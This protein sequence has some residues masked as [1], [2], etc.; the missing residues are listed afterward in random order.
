MK[1]IVRSALVVGVFL[2][3]FGIAQVPSVGATTVVGDRLNGVYKVGETVRWKI[4]QG[5]AVTARYRVLSGGLTEVAKGELSFDNKSAA[6][7]YTFDKPGTVLLDI[8]AK[9]SEN[10]EAKVLGGAVAEPEKIS[11][12]AQTPEDFD[13]FWTEQ[14]AKLEKIPTNPVLEVVDL[15]QPDIE[16]SKITMDNIKGSKIRGQLA[17]PVK[18]EKFPALLIVQWAGVYPLDKNWATGRAKEG[19]L[20]LNIIAHDL[21]IDEPASFYKEQND[22]PLKNY[23]SIGNDSRETSYFLRMY[24]SCYRAAE[25]LSKRAD[26]DGKTLVVMGA[27]QGGLQTLVTAGIHPKITG[28]LALVPA[29]CDMLGPEVGRAPG[30]PNWIWSGRGKDAKAVREA[31]RYYDVANFTSKIKCPVLIGVGLIDE[32]CPPAGVF[33]AANQIPGAK[34][35]MIMPK[36]DHQRHQEEY[37]KKCFGVWLP[38]LRQGQIPPVANP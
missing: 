35:V 14:I 30:W 38:A 18:G 22:G 1:L 28:A 11:R 2:A 20:T 33:A 9:D 23:T 17:K 10:K 25:Y 16:Y 4:D 15:K 27:S 6:I 34:D 26:W 37:Q 32:T 21:P 8:R 19:W 5:S 3:S 29:G 36:A 24:L 7:T 31:G 12:S 13:A